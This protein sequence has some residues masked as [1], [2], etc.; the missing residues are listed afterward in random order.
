[1]IS[2]LNNSRMFVR[3]CQPRRLRPIT[4]QILLVQYHSDPLAAI[5]VMT[6]LMNHSYFVHEFQ[7]RLYSMTGLCFTAYFP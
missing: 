4:W 7:V 2:R 1:M 3:Y 6:V 5:V